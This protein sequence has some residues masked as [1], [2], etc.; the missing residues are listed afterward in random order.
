ML[1]G[2]DGEAGEGSDSWIFAAG[3]ALADLV[4]AGCGVSLRVL[5]FQIT[6]RAGIRVFW[7][8]I[9]DFPRAE[10]QG[11]STCERGWHR[12]CLR[13]RMAQLDFHWVSDLRKTR[14]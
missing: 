14:L 1:P 2:V 5:W 4:V 9:W 3:E 13:V 7:G 10:V 11:S 8:E 6:E 12:P